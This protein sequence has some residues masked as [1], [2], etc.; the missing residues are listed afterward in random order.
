MKTTWWWPS[1]CGS[2]MGTFSIYP[3]DHPIRRYYYYLHCTDEETAVPTTW[4]AQC[5][6]VTHL[7][8]KKKKIIHPHQNLGM[9][10]NKVLRIIIS[11]QANYKWLSFYLKY[12]SIFSIL[13]VQLVKL[14]LKRNSS[15]SY[16]KNSILQY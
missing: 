6:I 9:K 11:E 12:F 4:F 15:M 2:L 8:I 1:F 5:L 13:S 14:F 16:L 3:L 10:Y 7:L